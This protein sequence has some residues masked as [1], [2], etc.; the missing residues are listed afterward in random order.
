[1]WATLQG[2]GTVAIHCLAGIHRAA[3]IT[4]CHFLYRHHVLGHTSATVRRGGMQ[5]EARLPC[6]PTGGRPPTATFAR[7]QGAPFRHGNKA[8]TSAAAT[9]LP[10]PV[11]ARRVHRRVDGRAPQRGVGLVHRVLAV[12]LA[13]FTEAAVVMVFASRRPLRP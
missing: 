1:M 7:L 12:V 6:G 2:G 3:M 4:A 11:P 5:R 13:L 9:A 10:V 8:A